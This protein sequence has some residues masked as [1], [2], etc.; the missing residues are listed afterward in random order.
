MY[1]VCIER[2]MVAVA[3]AATSSNTDRLSPDL[4]A[5]LDQL[6]D[7]SGTSRAELLRQAARDFLRRELAADEDPIVGVIGLGNTG[8]GAVS[9]EH[10]RFLAEHSARTV[11]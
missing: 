3:D 4:V 1:V 7:R 2:R 10:H 9:E 5:A 11:R 6:A 8:P